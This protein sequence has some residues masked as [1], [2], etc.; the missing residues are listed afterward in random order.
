M[1]DWIGELAKFKAPKPGARSAIFSQQQA[2]GRR[3]NQSQGKSIVHG[4]E[5]EVLFDFRVGRVQNMGE[6]RAEEDE[7]G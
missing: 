6:G 2:A 1:R 5:E 3:R 7:M 4:I